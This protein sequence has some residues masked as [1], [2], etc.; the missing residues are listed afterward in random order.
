VWYFVCFSIYLDKLI[1]LFNDL[2]CYE[3]ESIDFAHLGEEGTVF[4]HL[5]ED[6]TVFR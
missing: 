4:G 5:G 2:R 3:E 6:G 1:I